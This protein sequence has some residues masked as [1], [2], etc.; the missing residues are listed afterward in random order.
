[1]FALKSKIYYTNASMHDHIQVIRS[2]RRTLS[3]QVLSNGSIVVKSPTYVSDKDINKFIEKNREWIDKQNQLK[4]KL[5]ISTDKKY[6]HGE[7]FLYLGV[8]HTLEVG[9]YKTIEVSDNKILFPNFL[10]FRIQKELTAWY[11]SQ[12]KKLI[13]EQVEYY[14]KQMNVTYTTLSFSDTKSRWGACSHDNQLQFNWKLIMAPLLTLNYVV[15]HEL[16]HTTEKN[17]SRNFWNKVR[18]YNPSY[19]QQMKW[20]KTHGDSLV[21]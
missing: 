3:L 21:V 13:T 19:K 16:T 8:S 11:L 4:Q 5:S 2:K 18:F 9:N 6:E 14:A 12:A 17:H 20:L 1:M 7:Q 10:A 15:V